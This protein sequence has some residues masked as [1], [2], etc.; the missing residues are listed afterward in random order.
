MVVPTCVLVFCVAVVAGATSEPPG[1]EQR[2]VRRVAGKNRPKVFFQGPPLTTGA[3]A[4]ANGP[5]VRKG[6]WVDYHHRG[7]FARVLSPAT[8]ITVS[9]DAAVYRGVCC[10]L[11]VATQV[12]GVTGTGAPWRWSQAEARRKGARSDFSRFLLLLLGFER[13]KSACY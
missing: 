6:R 4:T 7:Q 11:A 13:T 10:R 1:L 2:V 9:S 5:W 8:Q 12:R 3:L